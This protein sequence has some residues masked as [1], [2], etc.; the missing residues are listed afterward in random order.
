MLNAKVGQTMLRVMPPEGH[1]E[2]F[3][4]DGIVT[5]V[6]DEEI[7]LAI[8]VDGG[9]RETTFCRKDGQSTSGFG[10]LVHSPFRQPEREPTDKK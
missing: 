1:G 3:A 2:G 4:Q 6:S 8:R 7:T 5:S 9:P 10:F